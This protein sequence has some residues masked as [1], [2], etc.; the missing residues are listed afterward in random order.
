MQDAKD[1]GDQLRRAV[2]NMPRVDALP[3]CGANVYDI[4]RH[5]FLIIT[6]PA[7]QGL[8]DRLTRPRNRRF[9]PTGY[10]WK[11][12]VKSEA[13]AK[14]RQAELASSFPAWLAA[15]RAGRQQADPSSSGGSDAAPY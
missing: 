13:A 2:Q 5:E 6:Q 7:L 1:G 10:D 3:A 4:V 9:K 12:W 11:E 8:M 14:E 15:Q